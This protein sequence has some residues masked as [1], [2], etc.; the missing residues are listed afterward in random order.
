MADTI[1]F[2]WDKGRVRRLVI[3]V[4]IVAALGLVLL[5][6]D[7]WDVKALGAAWIAALLSLAIALSRRAQTS[8]PVV[9][10]DARG[11][12]DSRLS[13]QVIPWEDIREVEA[14]EVENLTFVGIELESDAG[15]VGKLRPMH[16]MMRWPNRILR[17]PALSIAMHALDG[18]NSDLLAAVAQFRADLIADR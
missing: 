12:F 8:D 2:R 17:F 5:L 7:D 18:T 13:D 1:E 9:V 3:A 14:L 6:Q 16:R 4:V 15:I 10:V 11:I